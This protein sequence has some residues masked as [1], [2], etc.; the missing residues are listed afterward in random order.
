MQDILLPNQHTKEGFQEEF[1][2]TKDRDGNHALRMALQT[3]EQ[4]IKGKKPLNI[5]NCKYC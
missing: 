2:V 3:R 4:H 1:G 5:C